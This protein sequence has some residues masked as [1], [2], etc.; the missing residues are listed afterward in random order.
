MNRFGEIDERVFGGDRTSSAVGQENGKSG[1]G[2]EKWFRGGDCFS[3][4]EAVAGVPQSVYFS[5]ERLATKQCGRGIAANPH[6]PAWRICLIS[7]TFWD[8][9]VKRNLPAESNTPTG[10]C[11]P[12]RRMLHPPLAWGLGL[13]VGDVVHHILLFRHAQRARRASSVVFRSARR[14]SRRL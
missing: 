10:V 6:T 5:S 11:E 3:E 13:S 8:V 7:P 4:D 2:S 12:S 1:A 9:A 14:L